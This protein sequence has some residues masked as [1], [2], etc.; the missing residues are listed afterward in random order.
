[1]NLFL[2]FPLS[3]SLPRLLW[4]LVLPLPGLHGY[5]RRRR[6][7][8][9]P[10]MRHMQPG[11]NG[12]LWTSS[13]CASCSPGHTCWHAPQIWHHG[14][15]PTMKPVDVDKRSTAEYTKDFFGGFNRVLTVRTSPLPVSVCGAPGVRC[16]ASWS[17]ARK[18][19]LWSSTCSPGWG[20]RL[21][22]ALWAK[23]GSSWR[24]TEICVC[25][26]ES[27]SQLALVCRW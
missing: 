16:T 15:T 2:F 10:L 3:P 12:L 17:I 14:K 19:P 11:Y 25:E 9:P 5:C 8:M 26:L 22:L 6:G 13:V 18:T 24:H 7:P 27:S 1:M 4:L 20:T 23:Q 21:L